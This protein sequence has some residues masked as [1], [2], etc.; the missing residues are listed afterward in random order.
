[1]DIFRSADYNNEKLL[2]VIW[3]RNWLGH[4]ML[5]SEN[6]LSDHKTDWKITV[7]SDC[8]HRRR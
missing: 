6:I 3:R 5:F 4:G 8:S 2:K 1:M 7:K